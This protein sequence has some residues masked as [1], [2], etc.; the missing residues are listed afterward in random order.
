M[1]SVTTL[2]T[3]A[4]NIF[5][6]ERQL[7]FKKKRLQLVKDLEAAKALKYPHHSRAKVILARKAL[8]AFDESFAMEFGTV[9]TQLLNKVV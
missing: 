3:A 7:H 6:T 4:M 8:E 2:M 9:L 1:S 5:S